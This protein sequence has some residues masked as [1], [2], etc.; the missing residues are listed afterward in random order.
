MGKNDKIEDFIYLAA[1]ENAI[2]F[3]G[4]ANPKALLGKVLG[5]FQ[6]YRKDTRKAIELIDKVAEK[7]NALGLEKQEAELKKLV[8]DFFEA[9]KKKKKERKKEKLELPELSNAVKGK[10]VT[11]MP[12]EPSKYNHIGHALTFLINYMYA[13]K[14]NGKCVLRFEDT[15]PEKVSQEYVDA[16]IIDVLDYLDIKPDKIVYV[17]DDMEKLYKYGEILMKQGNAY[18]CFCEREEM[19]KNRREGKECKCRSAGPKKT[20]EEWKN[21]LNKKYKSGNCIV[22]LKIDMQ[23]K[24]ST[25]RDP[26]IFRMIARKHYKLGEKYYV[27][28]MYDFYASIEE[29]LCGITHVMR[30]A[31]FELRAELQ[32]HIRS[33]LKMPQP[34]TMVYGRFNIR[35]AITQGRDIRSL[36]EQGRVTGWDDPSLVTLRALKRRGIVKETYY[37]LAVRG[38]MSKQQTTIDWTVISTINRKFLDDSVDRYYFIADPVEI[39]VENAPAITATLDLHPMHRKGGRILRSNGKFLVEKEDLEKMKD[40]EMTRLMN[41][42]N[43]VKKDNKYIFDSQT[44]ED[45]KKKNGKSIIH[46]LPADDSNAKVNI[47]MPDNS[48]VDSIAESNI[49]KVKEGDIIQFERFAFVRLDDKK[50]WSFWFTHK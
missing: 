10:V 12:P 11:R 34:E 5:K 23:H 38:G 27:W 26:V 45:F 13:K 46:W 31:E 30:S 19:S 43:F 41:C 33:L 49:E 40:G 42:L 15:N 1:L 25:M 8:P 21:M 16:M 28:P 7:V 32:N 2:R 14:Y 24:N 50:D 9:E 18:V 3:K 20:L 17:S 4:K 47:R 6:E 39:I 48:F 22:R 29:N 36:I 37:E 35:G 44:H